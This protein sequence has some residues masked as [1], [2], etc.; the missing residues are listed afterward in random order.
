MDELMERMEEKKKIDKKDNVKK[1]VENKT[2]EKK[3]YGNKENK[4]AYY[5]FKQEFKKVIQDNI[6][7]GDNKNKLKE[8]PQKKS[9][10]TTVVINRRNKGYQKNNTESL[11]RTIQIPDDK[12][13]NEKTVRNIS[14]D[15]TTDYTKKNQRIETR[16][17]RNN[18]VTTIIDTKRK[19]AE[20]KPLQNTLIDR[21][22]ERKIYESN[23]Y[24]NKSVEKRSAQNRPSQE[25]RSKEMRI[26]I[27]RTPEI[28]KVQNKIQTTTV[29]K[30][31]RYETKIT[32]DNKPEEKKEN[33]KVVINLKN[34]N[35]N[36]K[37]EPLS[38]NKRTGT[39]NIQSIKKDNSN[40]NILKKEVKDIK[41][42][43]TLKKDYSTSYLIRKDVTK[44]STLKKDYSTSYLLKKGGLKPSILKKEYSNSNILRGPR[45]NLVRKEIKV[46][47]NKDGKTREVNRSVGY[48]RRNN[49]YNTSLLTSQPQQPRKQ[50]VSVEKRIITTTENNFSEKFRSPKV[51]SKNDS[52]RPSFSSY[53]RREY[54]VNKRRDE[55]LTEKEKEKEKERQ[56]LEREREKKK[57][58]M[59]R[60][61][62]EKEREKTREK[63]RIKREKERE[64]ERKEKER[65]EKEKER[66]TKLEKENEKDKDKKN[67]IKNESIEHVYIK[68]S[69][70][71]TLEINPKNIYT[72]K[73][74]T[75]DKKLIR[76]N[77]E[78]NVE[79]K[80]G[81]YILKGLNSP[82]D[83]DKDKEIVTETKTEIVIEVEKDKEIPKYEPY[84]KRG[85]KNI[86]LINKTHNDFEDD[87][88]E[89]KTTS[90]NTIYSNYIRT[91]KPIE[92][93]NLKAKTESELIDDLEKIENDNVKTFLRKD[94][95]DIYDSVNGE[96]DNFKKDVFYNKINSF[97]GKMGEF[98]QGK[99]PYSYKR[100]KVGDLNK[101]RDTSEDVYKKYVVHTKKYYEEKDDDKNI[102]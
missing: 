44:P 97:E 64:R 1:V 35:I 32:Q 4:N 62:K 13:T 84:G 24:V 55:P 53:T 27:N 47:S 96:I 46:T 77:T 65:K 73:I 91:K 54:F 14:K 5:E 3:E 43:G 76:E 40:S 37:K 75:E 50:V 87:K 25:R 18:Q 28:K 58:E 45:S 94:L 89:K 56:A 85:N 61:R 17:T 51:E 83:K 63:E 78:G 102:K 34:Y 79:R 12:K 6:K 22:K 68:K 59:E 39:Y 29:Y 69:K 74:I 15:V 100:R 86:R 33:T 26:E 52:S 60:E 48:R 92:K 38:N 20:K 90:N 49:N 11:I 95:L 41:K 70:I 8:E 71:P 66:Q 2:I 30:E 57:R 88:F 80:Y 99:M 10:F 67:S 19:P 7:S 9:N 42:P 81:R 93:N 101:G 16:T 72:R 98:D 82:K 31:T 21:R 23:P 36:D